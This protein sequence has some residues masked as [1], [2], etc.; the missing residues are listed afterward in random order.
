MSALAD[1]L[2][3]LAREGQVTIFYLEESGE[4]GIRCTKDGPA[5][6]D[7]TLIGAVRVLADSVVQ[8]KTESAKALSDQAVEGEESLLRLD[9]ELSK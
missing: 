9:R 6:R 3:Y 2:A 4:Y 1:V 5:T 8:R 7:R